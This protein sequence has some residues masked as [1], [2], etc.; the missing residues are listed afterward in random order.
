M[1][2]PRIGTGVLVWKDGQVLLGRRL[3]K[4]GFGTWSPPGGKLE[5]NERVAECAKRETIE[6]TEL[7]FSDPQ[8]VTFTDDIDKENGIHFVTLF[9]LADWIS[10]EPKPEKD[11]FEKWE[12]FPWNALPEPLFLPFAN[13]LKSGYK[14]NH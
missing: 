6:E 3:S 1:E 11:K 13:L 5:W 10:G 14:L 2:A 12:W 7:E 9:F 8:F 4:G